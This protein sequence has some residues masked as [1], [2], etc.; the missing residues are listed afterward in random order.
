MEA[1]NLPD[2]MRETETERETVAVMNAPIFNELTVFGKSD[3]MS[4]AVHDTLLDK[5]GS[6]EAYVIAYK[7][8]DVFKNAADILKLKAV[9]K[10]N[11]KTQ[12]VELA[13]K[14]VAKVTE[15]NLPK[16]YEYQDA[17]LEA[18]EIQLDEVK[19]RIK[20]RKEMLEALTAPVADAESGEMIYPAKLQEQGMTIAVKFV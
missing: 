14:I 16:K 1:N 20:A 17:L 11:A 9:N 6:V 7:W 10:S 8:A 5:Y 12:D 18:M 15:R 4:L 13:G 19:A 2:W 3:D